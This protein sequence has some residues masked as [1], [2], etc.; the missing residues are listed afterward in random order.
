[1]PD[2]LCGTIAHNAGIVVFLFLVFVVKPLSC[3]QLPPFILSSSVLFIIN[4]TT[5]HACRD[6][7]LGP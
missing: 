1:M 4:E 3:W 5:T 2:Y 6:Q 7:R